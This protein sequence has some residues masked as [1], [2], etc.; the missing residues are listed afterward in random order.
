M[1]GL[2]LGYLMCINPLLS[3]VPVC[4]NAWDIGCVRQSQLPNYL[5]YICYWFH[6]VCNYVVDSCIGIIVSDK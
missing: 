5:S 2:P 1:I 4:L 3:L 6:V